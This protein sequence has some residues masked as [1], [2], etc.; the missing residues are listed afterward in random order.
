MSLKLDL[1]RLFW[2]VTDVVVVNKNSSGKLTFS[3]NTFLRRST[4]VCVSSIA[5][6]FQTESKNKIAGQTL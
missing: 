1:D 2:H 5:P 6:T 4:V 3:S